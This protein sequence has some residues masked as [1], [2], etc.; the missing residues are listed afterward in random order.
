[1]SDQRI[2]IIGVSGENLCQRGICT[3]HMG[4]QALLGQH[5]FSVAKDQRLLE[6]T[7]SHLSFST[8]KAAVYIMGF[9]Y[10]FRVTWI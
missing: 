6:R 9:G 8:G 2:S 5:S 7:A 3:R 10:R 4:V 1:M